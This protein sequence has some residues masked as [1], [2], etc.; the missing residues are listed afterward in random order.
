MR[1]NNI[2]VNWGRFSMRSLVFGMASVAV[3]AFASSA[4]AATVSFV[5]GP[6]P[7]NGSVAVTSQSNGLVGGAKEVDRL[8]GGA[9]VKALNAADF[10]GENGKTLTLYNIGPFSRVVV[11]GVGEGPKTEADL[12]T[13]GGRIAQTT[14]SGTISMIVP[15]APGISN[16]AAFLA[17]GS[18][19]GTYD[20]GKWAKA[21]PTTEPAI[22]FLTP[23]AANAQVA[24]EKDLSAV[25]EGVAFTRD[26]ISTPSN[27][28]TPQHFVD[29]TIAA[30]AGISNV[31]VEVLGVPEMEKLGMG[32]I[33]GVGQGSSRPPRL[34]LV[35][36]NGAGSSAPIAFVGKGITFDS[37]GLS[38]KPGDGMWRMR[39][40][41]AGAAAS[42][43]AVLTAARRGAKVNVVGVAALAENMPDG[44][45][46]RPGDVLTSMS[47]KT[48]EIL[49]TDAEGRVVLGDAVWYVQERDKPAK[50]VTI[51][52]LT[53]AV[54]TALGNDYAGLFGNDE[55]FIAEVQSAAARADEG[56]WH[57]PIHP[58]TYDDIKSDIADVKNVV[59]G[60]GTAGSSIAAAYVS[61]WVKPGQTWA[62]LDIASVAWR[63]NADPTTP[64]GAVGFGVRLFDALLRQT[65]T[66]PSGSPNS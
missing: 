45:A 32:L 14:K 5:A 12:A 49:N 11:V 61:E 42:I 20:F 28:K 9:L 23:D 30:F 37:G 6:V 17:L 25:A 18:E 46:I 66:K 26:L 10:K 16:D 57:L 59:E 52:T 54:R 19:L 39:Y 60:S 40:D 7:Q 53:G 15:D 24:W 13:L 44:G 3:L 34:L 8:A 29:R 64:K 56:V 21:K 35:R 38:L 36:Y 33:L 27:I 50:V 51:G 48:T 43:G 62:H 4:Q 2:F 58:T 1:K 55:A 31:T 22:T 65:E 63:D 47:G 41:M